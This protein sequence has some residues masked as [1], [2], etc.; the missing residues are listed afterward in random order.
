[1]TTSPLRFRQSLAMRL[2]VALALVALIS[3]AGL[4]LVAY[5]SARASL[6]ARVTAQLTSIADLK[7]EQIITWL[8]ERQGDAR[9]LAVNK[10]N[11]DHL[12]EILSPDVAAD[13]KAALAAFTTDGLVGM[14]QARTG[15]KRIV[16]LDANGTVVLATEPTL[17]GQPTVHLAAIQE[18]LS[19]PEGEFVE[20]IHLES[21]MGLITMDFGHVIYAV[22]LDTGEETEEIIGVAIITVDM[23]E[24]IYPLIRAWPG[25]GTTGETL[26]IRA[27]GDST[28]FLNNLRFEKDAALNLRMPFSSPNAK[29]GPVVPRVSSRRPTTAPCRCWPPTVTFPVSIGASSLNKMLPRLLRRWTHSRSASGWLR[30]PCFSRYC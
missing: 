17:V 9:S 22:D 13:R 8:A 2:L 3:I 1:M 11:Q 24:T 6:E 26:L 29:W 20:D 30:E 14:Q 27:E 23:G 19:A 15:Y 21:D 18:M 28:L 5:Y 10:L 4:G 16:F 12:T 7:K 25:M